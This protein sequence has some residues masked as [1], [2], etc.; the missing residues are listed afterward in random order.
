MIL[1]NAALGAIIVLVLQWHFSRYWAAYY[2]HFPFPGY[3]QAAQAATIPA[4]L[5]TS[6][7]TLLVT[8]I[9]LCLLPMF[10]LRLAGSRLANLGL[11]LLALWAGVM[12][13]AIGI[14]IATPRLRQDS[15]MWPIDLLMLAFL[16]G[17]PLAVGGLVVLAVRA[18]IP[19]MR[20]KLL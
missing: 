4:Y 2:S 1:V 20:G 15:N 16:T 5:T 7:R 17:F 6:S 19:S 8:E 12:C 14:W 9:A 3:E 11:A 10:T 18:L 13:S